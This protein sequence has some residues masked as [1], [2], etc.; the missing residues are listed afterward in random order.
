MPKPADL[1]EYPNVPA[2]VSGAL[3]RHGIADSL[4]L[5]S[6]ASRAKPRAALA[7]ETGVAH[8]EL[9]ELVCLS[10]LSRIQWVSPLFARLVHDAGFKTVKDVAKASAGDL[11]ARV[12]AV[13]GLLKLFKGKIGEKD[14]GRL[15]YLAARLPHELEG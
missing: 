5:W 13:N 8:G 1:A 7:S 11:A 4:S 12:A 9:F 10:D 6:A 2:A 3:A 14:M 15:V